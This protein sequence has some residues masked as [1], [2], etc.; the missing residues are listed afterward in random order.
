MRYVLLAVL[1]VIGCGITEASANASG[2]AKRDVLFVPSVD[3]T[4]DVIDQH[5]FRRVERIDA[6]P[7]YRQCVGSATNPGEA[8]ACLADNQLAAEGLLILLDDLRVS[9]NGRTIYVSRP[10]LG[11]VVAIDLRTEE[12]LWHVEVSGNHPDH[13]ALS[14]DGRRLLVSAKSADLVEVI[15]TRKARIVDSFPTGESPHGNDFSDD[16]ELVYNGSLGR[17]PAPDGAPCRCW[18]TIVE[19]GTMDVRRVIEFDQGV[20][21]FVVMPNGKTAYIQLTFLHG[22]VEYSLE[23]ERVL[24]TV[25]LPFAE[26]VAPLD[27]AS[28]PRAS[29]NHGIAINAARTRICAA[30]TLSDYAAIVRRRSLA[31]KHVV[32]VGKQPAWA[33]SSDDGRFCFVA[34]R[35]SD[36]LSVISYR[37]GSELARV[38]VGDNPRRMRTATVRLP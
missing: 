30:A 2:D 14:P 36:D 34:N 3:G 23:E 24:R 1:C 28:D 25:E 17:G 31:V 22:F 35:E 26:G 38:P 4:V 21:P 12:L 8:A 19:A 18:L 10:S 11:D 37:T 33:T 7:D 29:T 16:G 20:R 6:A 5:G 13:L 15:N 9:P 32:P 27:P